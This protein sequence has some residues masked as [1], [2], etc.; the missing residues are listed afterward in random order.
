MIYE[1][2]G[3]AKQRQSLVITEKPVSTLSLFSRIEFNSKFNTKEII[4][5]PAC[6]ANM[7]ILV[8]LQL[9]RRTTMMLTAVRI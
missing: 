8:L 7:G 6:Y 9:Q 2:T 3:S 5:V 4:I 1:N